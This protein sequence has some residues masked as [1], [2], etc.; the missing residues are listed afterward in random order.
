[1]IYQKEIKISTS[2]HKHL[3]DLTPKIQKLL[4]E[5]EVSTGLV[6]IFN[7]GS[8]GA[9]IS[10]QF[11]PGLEE[12]IPNILDKLIP[13]NLDYG[14]QQTWHDDNGHSH[15]QA[16]LLGASFTVPFRDKKLLLGTYQQIVHLECDVVPHERSLII[17]IYSD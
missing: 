5:L 11:E 17:T 13:A 8:T 2:G 12:D 15:I 16:V 9:I 3:Q 4:D 14:H 1:M 7:V 10:T 6:N